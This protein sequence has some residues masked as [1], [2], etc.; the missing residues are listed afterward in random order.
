MSLTYYSTIYNVFDCNVTSVYDKYERCCIYVC[1]PCD[2]SYIM[3]MTD[4]KSKMGL[5]LSP[6]YS[7]H[8]GVGVRSVCYLVGRTTPDVLITV[9]QLTCCAIV[10]SLL[11]YFRCLL[12]AL[13]DLFIFSTAA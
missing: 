10:F 7:F 5:V 9:S 1:M 8:Q 11:I 6:F 12:S 13:S 3:C 4:V 2:I